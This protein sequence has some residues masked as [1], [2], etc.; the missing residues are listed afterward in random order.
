MANLYARWQKDNVIAAMKTRR[1]VFLSG[2]R[3]CGKTTLA[4]QLT[5]PQIAFRTLD[6]IGMR[7]LA[8]ADP[9]DFLT[10]SGRTL[11]IDEIQRV[12][13]LLPAIK[14]MVDEN[15]RPGQFL[16]TGSANIQALPEVQESLAGRITTVHLRPLTQGELIGTKPSFLS[17]A[18]Q[19]SFKKKKHSSY[20]RKAVLA[21]AIAGGFPEAIKLNEVERRKWH[22]DYIGALLKRD[23]QEIARINRQSALQ[24]LVEILAAWSSKYMDISAIGSGLSIRRATIESYL[25]ALMTLYL[26]ESVSPWTD[27]D[28]SR[29]GKRAK[30]FMT[31]CGLMA[32]ILRWRMNQVELDADRA[33]KLIETFVFNE[34]AAQIDASPGEYELFHYRDREQHEIDF[35]I[36]REDHALLGIEVKAGAAI[37]HSDFRHL[38]WFRD[39]IANDRPF[40]GIVLYTGELAGSMGDNLWAVPIGALWA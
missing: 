11:I 26:V 10:H 37:S 32:S 25:N 8:E 33:G 12:P 13:N 31:D 30:L 29:V 5:G 21:M 15:T 20:G 18:F 1:V 23:L 35:L 3:Q 16:L 28:Y 34:I 6:D 38:K 14:K 9:H 17:K 27:T 19:Q 2:S 22:K 39:N 36:E 4:K 7:Q 24:K 40:T